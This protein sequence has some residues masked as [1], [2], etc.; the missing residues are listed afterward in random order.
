MRLLSIRKLLLYV[1]T[2][3]VVYTPMFGASVLF[4]RYFVLYGLLII[5]IIPYIARRDSGFLK[6]LSYRSVLLFVAAI[7]V[8][9]LLFV[10][11]Q[12]ANGISISSLE[13]TRLIQ[14]NIIVVMILHA[15]II[16]DRFR[17]IGYD[18][19]DIVRVLLVF[20]TL[21]GLV[22]FLGLVL[23]VFKEIAVFFYQNTGGFNDFVIQSRIYGI[24][25]DYTFGTPVY[26]GMLASVAVYFAILH[27]SPR[28]FLYVFPILLVTLLNGRTGIVVFCIMTASFLVY[29]YAKKGQVIKII[30]TV[31]GLVLMTISLMTLLYRLS[32]ST[33]NFVNS[34]IQDTQ[35]LVTDGELSGNY[36]ILLNDSISMPDADKLIFGEGYRVYGEDALHEKGFKSDIG[37]VN[38]LYMGGVVFMTLIYL[39]FIVF[40]M[41]GNR[42]EYSFLMVMIIAAVLLANIKGEAFRSSIIM[43]L[44]IYIKL[45]LIRPQSKENTYE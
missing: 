28:L 37:Y 38:D 42:R 40:I 4:D 43:F 10:M 11:I 45:L 44:P 5:A 36:D 29:L 12:M 7:F 21:Q 1:Y 19:L 41:V 16:I 13:D 6:I 22:A 27:K 3:L 34:F 20:A 9:S 33:Y 23:P 26:H 2:F 25:S 24:S 14:N 8:S 32:P 18:K 39:S 30:G 31:T 17:K 35:S 15:A